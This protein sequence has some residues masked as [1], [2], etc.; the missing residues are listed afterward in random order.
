MNN[1]TEWL[2]K[3]SLAILA[4]LSPV[5]SIQLRAGQ[6]ITMKSYNDATT[7]TYNGTAYFH[8]LSLTRS[9]NY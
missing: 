5:K 9:E 2:M 7:P 3:V 6:T 1:F 4:V 8:Q